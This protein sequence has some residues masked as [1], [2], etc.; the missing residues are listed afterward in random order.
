M[1]LKPLLYLKGVLR[2]KELMLRALQASSEGTQQV[3]SK[4]THK[5]H[6]AGATI[7]QHLRHSLTHIRKVTDRVGD[8]SSVIDY[9]VRSRGTQVETNALSAAEEVASLIETTTQFYS[10]TDMLSPLSV[11]FMFGAGSGP[12][13]PEYFVIP[14]SLARE[15]TFVAHHAIHHNSSILLIIR[16]NPSVF[17]DLDAQLLETVPDFGVAPST[18]VF[19]RDPD[20]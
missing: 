8:S 4:L 17:E 12:H 13:S 20:A 10:E 2:Q 9:D 3:N 14:S 7:G 1:T 15:L 18:V 16:N 11:Q 19:K 6:L 5:C